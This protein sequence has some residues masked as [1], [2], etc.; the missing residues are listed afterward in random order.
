MVSP[1]QVPVPGGRVDVLCQHGHVLLRVMSNEGEGVSFLA[2][3][4]QARRLALA[5]LSEANRT[6]AYGTGAA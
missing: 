1:V 2:R 4:E 3:P 5:L 6:D